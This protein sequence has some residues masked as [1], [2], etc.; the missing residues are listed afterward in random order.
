MKKKKLPIII[1]G[2]VS[3]FILSACGGSPFDTH[4]KVDEFDDG[5]V[6][7]PY[8]IYD[9]GKRIT[10]IELDEENV[11]IDRTK[12]DIFKLYASYEPE[13]AFNGYLFYESS[14]EEVATIDETGLITV[15]KNGSTTITVSSDNGIAETCLVNVYT[16]LKELIISP[17]S[18]VPTGY[19]LDID[20]TRQFTVS[21]NP[22][23]TNLT[24]VIWSVVDIN[25]KPSQ[26]AS[27]DQ[28]GLLT[29][30]APKKCDA[31]INL[32]IATSKYDETIFAS[33]PIT[34]RD[35]HTYASGV[36][37]HYL[38]TDYSKCTID[39]ALGTSIELE[40]V[41]SP[42]TLIRP[43][44][45]VSYDET[46]ATVDELGFVTAKK[47][48]ASTTIKVRVDEVENYV[49]INTTKVAVTSLDLN[50]SSIG[51]KQGD[52][53]QLIPTISPSNASVKD[54]SYV[55]VNGNS[56]VSVSDTGLVTASK[57]SKAEEALIK[58]SS[59]D[60]S[61][62]YATCR[63][64]VTNPVSSFEINEPTNPFY[65]GGN[66]YQLDLTVN[67]VDADD[68]SVVWE[69]DSPSIATIDTN[70]GLV[71]T[72]DS[73]LSGD[74][75][76][77]A[78][79]NSTLVDSIVVNVSK[80]VGEFLANKAY[81]VGNR[82]FTSYNSDYS[83]SSW[84]DSDYAKELVEIGNGG[85][86]DFTNQWVLANVTFNASDIWKIRSATYASA[87]GI[88]PASNEI[89]YVTDTDNICTQYTGEY[90]IY[91]QQ[92]SA[93]KQVETG[94]DYYIYGEPCFYSDSF[95]IV[96][97]KDYS[98]GTSTGTSEANSSWHYL[99][100][101]YLLTLNPDQSSYTEYVGTISFKAN[102]EFRIRN[103]YF[104]EVAL[105]TASC[106]QVSKVGS[107]FKINEDGTYALYFKPS[108]GNDT[109]Y[110]AKVASPV[111]PTSVTLSESAINLS[112]G[113][114]HLLSATVNPANASNK[115][116]SWSSSDPTK[117]SVNE[118]GLVTA[119]A[120]SGTVTITASVNGFSSITANCTVTLS[121][122][123][124]TTKMIY[125]NDG[126]SSLWNQA[127]AKFAVWSY[128]TASDGKYIESTS[129][130][131][132]NHLFTV[133][134][135]AT[136]I[137]F[138]RV[139]PNY[140]STDDTKFPPLNNDDPNNTVIGY[141]NKTAD[142]YSTVGSSNLFTITGWGGE[143]GSTGNW[144]NI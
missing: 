68:Y 48:P 56:F 97:N 59:V 108:M 79:V 49:T 1:L 88:N 60:D 120:S 2:I 95:Y 140:V 67:P 12:T 25:G 31:T 104:F 90:N 39:V 9:N 47:A 102:D 94:Y 115:T 109:L 106:S 101:S 75:T 107:N 66:E 8:Q 15:H 57:S 16:P 7:T 89:M 130:V 142:E 38:G 131:G 134:I 50:Y 13:D 126:G 124:A 37:I 103:N 58:V 63:I 10:S 18:E 87:L 35:D 36:E 33:E 129:K 5:K 82:D 144:S 98:S 65:Y 61:T 73:S 78:T 135:E 138:I 53:V 122:V 70:T 69:S 81:L 100:R 3:A 6:V 128:S 143:G 24:D 121:D 54:V 113:S 26:I 22:S 42:D 105:D 111:N 118:L 72:N 93:A 29:V 46:V 17:H 91:Y 112:N 123:P 19:V 110:V 71:T 52:T 21:Y 77:T 23:D 133:P 30:D 62:V 83:V 132:N 27:I 20:E 116:V 14:D 137:I 43:I 11:Q 114:S 141:W 64:V 99:S 80:P 139:N 117:A 119:H 136:H 55:V 84:D 28:N 51:M 74:V 44:S 92:L 76:F 41:I 34:I 85:N 32:V 45:W 96:G 125:L 86:I 127:G 40:A 4:I